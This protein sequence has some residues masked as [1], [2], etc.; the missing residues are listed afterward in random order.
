MP[1]S[2]LILAISSRALFDLSASNQV[3]E[4]EGLE[5]YRRYQIAHEDEVLAPGEGFSFI[6]KLLTQR[7][8]IIS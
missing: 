7:T 4:S 1:D 6:K 3:Y 5:S 2:Q 8:A